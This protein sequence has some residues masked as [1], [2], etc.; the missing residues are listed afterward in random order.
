MHVYK[1]E[2]TN[3]I[4]I[5]VHGI[6]CLI[7]LS[8][9]VCSCSIDGAL[10]RFGRFDKEIL[11]GVPDKLGRL[12]ILRIHTKNMKLTDDVDIEK[13]AAECHGYVGSDLSSLCSEAALQHVRK[14]CYHACI[15]TF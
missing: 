7:P 5:V 2:L 8:Q 13:I 14:S 6:H 3:V 4:I 11:V 12:E 10:R 9:S 15:I 1:T